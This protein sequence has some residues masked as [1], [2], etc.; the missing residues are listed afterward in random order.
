MMEVRK[1][2]P[3]YLEAEWQAYRSAKNQAI[4][5]AAEVVDYLPAY[6][7]FTLAPNPKR[8]PTT[9]PTGQYKSLLSSIFL[10]RDL[11]QVFTKFLFTPELTE[12][13]NIH[14]HGYYSVKDAIKYH[15]WFLP[16]CKSIGFIKIKNNVDP[17]WVNEY[18]TK[19]MD[20]MENILK[21]DVPLPLTEQNFD[22]YKE[23]KPKYLMRRYL[24]NM[25]NKVKNVDIRKYL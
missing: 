13:G 22:E 9:N 20:E 1:L 11:K 17:Y 10:N 16:A 24:L 23:Y 12:E 19:D 14:I 7:A 5:Y 3:K 25:S 4:T 21:N 15:R 8:F 6:R 18:V 2:N